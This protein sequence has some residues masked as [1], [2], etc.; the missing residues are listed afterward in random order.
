MKHKPR[1]WYKLD[2]AAVMYSSLQQ[3]RY[4]AIY[5]LSVM[6][7]E[8]VDVAALQRAIDKT[9]PRFPTFSVKI[10]RGFFWYYLEPNN[11]P[12][13]FVKTDVSDP[14]QPI[15][16]DEDNG[17]LVRF[18][19]YDRRISFECFHAL[20]DGV[21]ALTFLRTLIAVYLREMG[22]DIP[23]EQGILDV[24]ETPHPEEMENAY[25][26]YAGP[27]VPHHKRPAPMAYQNIGTPEPFFTYHVTMGFVPVD[28]LRVKAKTYGVS[29]TEYLGAVLMQVL[30][31]KQKQEHPYRELPVALAIPVNLRARFPSKTLR[32][33]ITTVRLDID[34]AL[35]EYSFPEIATQIHHMMRLYATRQEQQAAITDNIK[36]QTNRFLKMVP[37]FVKNPVIFLY[38]N[39]LATRPY[40]A[41]FTNPGILTV[42]PSMQPYIQHAEAIP[43]QATVARPHCALISYNN[44]MTITFA[45]TQKETDTEREFFRFLVKEGIPVRIE[46]NRNE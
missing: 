32:N 18:Y 43:G 30:L 26:R 34:P 3:E 42:P 38:Y 8:T 21:G 12:G 36:L 9:M 35:G 14:C 37:L 20:A 40:S 46:S 45:G 4:S 41:I 28:A 22:H 27:Q 5:R 1:K 19:A 44:T 17:W 25:A 39:L 15:R 13:P 29:I 7:T 23:D 16:Y 10:R 6:M 2:T 33:F 31:Q 11:A 24:A